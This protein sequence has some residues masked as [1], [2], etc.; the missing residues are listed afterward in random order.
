[1]AGN[2]LGRTKEEINE[3]MKRLGIDNKKVKNSLSW[4]KK[5]I[6]NIS[7]HQNENIS[8]CP[9]YALLAL[10]AYHIGEYSLREKVISSLKERFLREDGL[11]WGDKNS[12]DPGIV[13]TCWSI[14]ALHQAEDGKD[15][16]KECMAAM[17]DKMYDSPDF[18][19]SRLFF[20]F[21]SRANP[22]PELYPNALAVIALTSLEDSLAYDAADNMESW[23]KSADPILLK[24]DSFDQILLWPNLYAV[25]A[26]ANLGKDVKP[27]V[28]TLK[29][30]WWNKSKKIFLSEAGYKLR[31]NSLAAI[32][33]GTIGDP[34]EDELLEGIK[35]NFYNG[36]G[37]FKE[38][39]AD[40]T[41][42]TSLLAVL[43]FNRYRF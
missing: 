20:E 26:F 33:L 31:E 10:A 14:L 24:K 1:M 4:T 19:G 28:D 39:S 41:E 3:V 13:A 18:R 29:D 17:K 7:E 36:N 42:M 22:L 5:V 8:F 40:A 2:L 23:F 12:P 34:L 15:L 6:D 11:F 16:A 21:G 38:G 30:R 32:A 25:I 27:Y 9:Q 43:A 35:K 37:K